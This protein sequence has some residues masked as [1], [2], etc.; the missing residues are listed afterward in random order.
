M[1]WLFAGIFLRAYNASFMTHM[2]LEAAYPSS[3]RASDIKQLQTLLGQRHSVVLVG[4]KRVG[5]SNFLRFFI[6]KQAQE[7]LST[8][9]IQVEIDL[10]QLYELSTYAFWILFLKTLIDEAKISGMGVSNEK[11][12]KT[13]LKCIELHDIFL[14]IEEVKQLLQEMSKGNRQVVIYLLRFDRTTPLIT[15][16]FFANIQVL[17]SNPDIQFVFTSSRPLTELVPEVFTTAALSVFCREMYLKPATPADAILIIKTFEERYHLALSKKHI[18]ELIVL[19]GGHVQYLHLLLLILSENGGG[20]RLPHFTIHEEVLAL[21]E[22]IFASLNRSEQQ[23]LL[24]NVDKS[25]ATADAPKY[26]LETGIVTEKATLFNPLFEHYLRHSTLK[27]STE[28]T[29]K[30]HR[31]LSL[32]QQ[33]LGELVTRDEIIA[34][35]WPEQVELGVTDWAVDRLVARLRKK[36]NIISPKHHIETVVSRGYKLRT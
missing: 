12:D 13:F 36:L 14:L 33:H 5:I 24:K 15:P 32:L 2:P 34:A 18:E 29:K 19:A 35:V 26:L 31:L 17:A 10:N 27:K 21:S 22:E 8:K 20:A 25:F 7:T 30:E 28:L 4:M 3:F 23:F 6:H 1:I 11:L 9:V 16:D